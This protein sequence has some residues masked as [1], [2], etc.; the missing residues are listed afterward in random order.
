MLCFVVLLL[1]LFV[2][3]FVVLLVFVVEASVCDT[4]C[5]EHRGEL[6]VEVELRGRGPRRGAVKQ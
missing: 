6:D 2:L 1:F 5:G 3:V 4:S